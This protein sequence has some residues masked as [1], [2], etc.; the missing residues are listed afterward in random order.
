MAQSDTWKGKAEK[1]ER[2]DFFGHDIRRLRRRKGEADRASCTLSHEYER[3]DRS[4]TP[5][6]KICLNTNQSLSRDRQN[7]HY[8]ESSSIIVSR[9]LVGKFSTT[10]H[11]HSHHLCCIWISPGNSSREDMYRSTHMIL[12][13]MSN[14]D[15][16]YPLSDAHHCR[17]SNKSYHQNSASNIW[18]LGNPV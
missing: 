17:I 14:S 7:S 9:T 3:R 18:D 13:Y 15:R 6:L 16:L 8:L 11:K 1:N 4:S 12:N 10:T 2:A 5:T